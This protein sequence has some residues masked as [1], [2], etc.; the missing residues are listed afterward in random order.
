MNGL[1]GFGVVLLLCFGFLFFLIARELWC[2]YWKI[3]LALAKAD[4]ALELLKTIAHNSATI[5]RAALRANPEPTNDDPQNRPP[6]LST[7]LAANDIGT[8]AML[9]RLAQAALEKA[10][11]K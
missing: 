2:W 1:N 4:E 7:S 9:G 10:R 3:N 11:K 5:A 8:G 6:P